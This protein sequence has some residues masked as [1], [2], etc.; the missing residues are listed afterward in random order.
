MSETTGVVGNCSHCNA[1]PTNMDKWKYTLITTVLFLIIVN[2]V[3]YKLVNSLLKRFVKIS[4]V[5]GC[6][7]MA[8]ILVHAF[9][10]T[11]VLRMLM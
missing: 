9:V 2:P 5:D 11:I 7:T 1:K 10:F 3:T 8:G 4:S 6:P